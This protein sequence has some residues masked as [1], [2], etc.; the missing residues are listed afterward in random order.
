[1]KIEA[2]KEISPSLLDSLNLK[3]QFENYTALKAEIDSLSLKFQKIGFIDSELKKLEKKNDSLFEAHF[4]L[5]NQWKLIEIKYRAEDFSISELKKL[6]PNV[7]DTVFTIPLAKA[8]D[9]LWALTKQNVEKGDPFSKIQLSNIQKKDSQFLTAVL[10]TTSNNKR[11]IDGLVVKG[12]EKFPKPFLKYYAGIKKGATFNQKKLIEK[13]ELLNSLGFVS[14]IKPPEA[15]FKKD[16]TLIYFYLEKLENNLFDGILGFATNEETQKIEFNGYLSLEL[17][18]NLNY[19]EQ[20]SVNYKADGREQQN[21][22][23]FTK[24]PYLFKSPFGISMELELFKR[25]STFST[26]H[27][28]ARLYYQATPSLDFYIG[29]KSYE[30]NNLLNEANAGIFVEDFT[31]GFALLGIHYTKLQN[32]RLFPI[33][34]FAGLESEI[35][36]RSTFNDNSKQNKFS[37]TVQHIFNLNERNSIFIK[38]HTRFLNSP[39][40]LTNELFRF[41]GINSLR[42]FRENS[43]DASLFSALTTEYR[44]LLD[45][46]AY[47]HSIIDIAY[48]ENETVN[49]NEELYGF[50]LGLGLNTKAGLFKFNIANGF[51]KNQ[52]IRFDNT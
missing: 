21:L 48:F 17:N 47:V 45:Q 44:Y 23:I 52:S 51:S 15:L 9:L 1:M 34:T 4:F 43:I 32:E 25:D 7:N 18:N 30:S 10:N 49:I 6:I 42:G 12:Y 14:T 41:G 29:Y 37:G 39:N 38:N 2:E 24:L 46:N 11:T 35:G 13:N 8:E 5:G 19:G 3:F 50:G 33:K 22:R 20:L 36:N 40:Y 16:S 31:S 26:T 27:Q 28:E